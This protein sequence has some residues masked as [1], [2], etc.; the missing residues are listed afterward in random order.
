MELLD[1][2]VEYRY[3]PCSGELVEKSNN[4]L[5]C[6]QCGWEIVLLEG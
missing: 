5:V 6:K 4:R 1:Y 3:C 2:C